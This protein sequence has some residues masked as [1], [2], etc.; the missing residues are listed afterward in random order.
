MAQL[1][2]PGRTDILV[3]GDVPVAAFAFHYDAVQ[4]YR[5]R[6]EGSSE[7]LAGPNHAAGAGRLALQDDLSFSNDPV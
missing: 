4:H 6:K 1:L 5:N 7:E 2:A 3:Q